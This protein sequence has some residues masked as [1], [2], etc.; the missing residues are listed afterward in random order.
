MTKCIVEKKIDRQICCACDGAGCKVC[1]HTGIWKESIY[2]H[3]YK[4]KSGQLV[5]F[6]GDTIK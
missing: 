4:D 1:K 5:C 3:T 2:Y 6:D